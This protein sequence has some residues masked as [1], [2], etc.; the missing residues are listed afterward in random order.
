MA[1]PEIKDI[2]RHTDTLALQTNMISLMNGAG[3]QNVN[4]SVERTNRPGIQMVTNLTRIASYNLNNV[5]S[6]TLSNLIL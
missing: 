3:F 2:H 5:V 1:A 6:S 4:V